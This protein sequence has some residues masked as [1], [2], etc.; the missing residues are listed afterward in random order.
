MVGK[1]LRTTSKEGTN[2]TKK[3]PHPSSQLKRMGA[4]INYNKIH[5]VTSINLNMKFNIPICIFLHRFYNFLVLY[6]I[7]S[8]LQLNFNSTQIYDNKYFPNLNISFHVL[9]NVPIWSQCNYIFYLLSNHPNL[10]ISFF[11]D[12]S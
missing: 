9:F 5:Y 12:T 10:Y 6:Y 11:H 7:N 1:G 8:F 4:T 2:L 3:K